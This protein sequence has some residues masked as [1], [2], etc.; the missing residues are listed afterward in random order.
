MSTGT[1]RIAP[2]AYQ[3]LRDALSVVFWYRRPFQNFLRAALRETPELL[4]GLNFDEPERVV[5]DHLVDRLL[6]KEAAYRDLTVQLMLEAASM[7]RF[8]D[9]E[10]HENAKELIAEAERAVAELGRWT[11]RYRDELAEHDRVEA[12]A[13][14]SRSQQEALRK[15]GQDL[16]ALKARFLD[17]QNGGDAAGRGNQFQG[18]LRDLF[19]LFDMEPRLAYSLEHEQIDGSLS[20]DTDDYIVEA[21]WRK[22]PTNREHLDVLAQKV[23]RKGKNALGLYA[24]VNGFTRDGLDTYKEGTPF[25]TLDG[26]DLFL[27]LDQRVR[28]DDLLRR[29]KRHANETGDCYY[30][31]SRLV[32]D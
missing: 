4:A 8:P 12:E 3:A 24:S 2:G 25:V 30:P 28:L 22:E 16:D 26:H 10:R 9:L 27:V 5:A 14:A 17:M 15:F 7:R 19:A 23:R 31:A 32:S 13:R 21:R 6:R 29:K 20:F 1:K 11:D 18:F